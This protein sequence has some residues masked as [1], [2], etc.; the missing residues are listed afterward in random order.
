MLLDDSDNLPFK[1]KKIEVSE[2]KVEENWE[3][4]RQR[5]DGGEVSYT[6]PVR[7]I[8]FSV[9]A[10]A[11]VFLCALFVWKYMV[12]PAEPY[13]LYTTDFGKRQRIVLPDQSVVILNGH[14]TLKVPSPWKNDSARTVFL[15]GEAYF[16]VTKGTDPQMAPFIVNTKTLQVRVLGTKFNVN[17]YNDNAFVALKEGKVEVVYQKNQKSTVKPIYIKPG[18]L[19]KMAPVETN[20]PPA[21]LPVEPAA[22]A[23]WKDDTFHFRNT[24]LTEIAGM[25]YNQYG[26]T[27]QFN[28]LSLM[29]RTMDGHLKA[30]NLDELLNAIEITLSL[31]IEKQNDKIFRVSKK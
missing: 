8:I 5:I 27:L 22:I 20:I 18:E 31:K 15:T 1:G 30:E 29:N 10:A 24:P 2:T 21:L 14:S 16:E 25:V 13:I 6:T 28:D 11:A 4:I 19:V 12:S 23:D 9:A 17:A 3:K 7:R 26:V